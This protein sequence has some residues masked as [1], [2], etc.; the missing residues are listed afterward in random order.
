V[1]DLGDRRRFNAEADCFAA[2]EKAHIARL[3]A[4]CTASASS[5]FIPGRGV[6]VASSG[7]AENSCS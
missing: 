2:C 5:S 6:P 7:G 4:S 3:A 1:R